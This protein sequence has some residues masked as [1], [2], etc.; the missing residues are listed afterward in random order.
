M[1]WPKGAVAAVEQAAGQEVAGTTIPSLEGP[2]AQQRIRMA[3]L[4][5]RRTMAGVVVAADSTA[6]GPARAAYRILSAPA[7][8]A[9]LVE[10]AVPAAPPAAGAGA[11]L[12]VMARSSPEAQVSARMLDSFLAA[13]AEPADNLREVPARAAMAELVFNSPTAERV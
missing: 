10:L 13:A 1:R 11:A 12:A 7:S 3:K 9:E 2:E 4:G 5:S 6:M 8:R